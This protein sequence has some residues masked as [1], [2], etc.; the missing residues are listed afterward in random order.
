MANGRGRRCL[1]V[2]PEKDD[3]VSMAHIGS[4]IPPSPAQAHA[5]HAS[6]TTPLSYTSGIR[7]P[8][9]TPRE[10]SLIVNG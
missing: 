10:S 2:G 4:N 3:G 5:F 7:P 9:F 1:I 6:V 8:G